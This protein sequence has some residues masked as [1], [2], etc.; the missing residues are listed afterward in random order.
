MNKYFKHICITLICILSLVS[1]IKVNANSIS[2]NQSNI[3]LGV[4]TNETITYTLASGLS[5]EDIIW[6]SSNQSVATINSSGNLTALNIGTT[7]ITA[8]INGISDT[9]KVVVVS[10]YVAISGITLNKSSTTLLVGDSETLKVTISP[11]NATNKNITW[12]SSNPTIA[13][14]NSS[15]YVTAKSVGTATITASVGSYQV[16]CQV[17]V[18]YSFSLKGISLDKTNISIKEKAT[19]QLNV[20]YNPSNATNKKV[21]WKS[22]NT[23]VATVNQSGLVTAI[24]KGTATITVVSQDGGYVATCE[25]T[26]QEISKK[27]TEIYLDKNELSLVSGET[28]ELKATIKPDYA[29]NKN[30]IWES[31]NES[32]ATVENGIIKTIS[33][34]TI[35]IK[36]K[37]EDGNKEAICKVT[38][39]APPLQEITFSEI[40]KTVYLDSETILQVITKPANAVIENPIWTSSNETVATVENGK[41]HARKLGQTIITVSN[42]DNTISASI[43]I[44][45][46]E[47]PKE[48]L[49]ITIKGYNLN[50]E[51]KTTSYNLSIG[52]EE[53]LNITTN[54]ENVTI[55]GN[56]NLKNGSIITITVED[57]VKTT[58]VINIKKKQNFTIYFIAIISIL[59]LINLIRIIVNNK[60]QKKY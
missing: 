6:T 24:S 10:D 8:T 51:P 15:G 35:E 23:N 28:A 58:Y 32:I 22:S 38:V 55:K 4:G 59:L 39:T 19:S 27:V 44:T 18:T 46:I 14:V 41:V 57:N 25:V 56:K 17:T 36:A 37:S 31:S 43:N 34:G 20:I 5:S 30:V 29:E 3:T 7:I 45:V 9:C 1:P 11:S 13:T 50:F 47:K 21:T 53:E 16:T 49:N 2:I 52:N 26:V 12:K 42:A 60:K 54:A 33:P 48:P 40:E